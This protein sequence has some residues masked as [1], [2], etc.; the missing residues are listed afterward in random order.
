M[1]EINRF[2]FSSQEIDILTNFQ[3]INPSLVFK[4]T[5]LETENESGSVSGFYN[6]DKDKEFG[7]FGIYLLQ[8]FITILKE[9]NDHALE[10]KPSE[11]EVIIHDQLNKSKTSYR[12]TPVADS[13]M[14]KDIKYPKSFSS[15][16]EVIDIIFRADK[17]AQLRKIGDII[18]FDCVYINT[19]IND[20]VR[21]IGADEDRQN[22]E[23]AYEVEINEIDVKTNALDETLVIKRPEFNMLLPGY[24]Y[25]L[26]VAKSAK[27][28]YMTNW[29][30]VG[31]N[32]LEYF[33]GIGKED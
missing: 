7:E 20:I 19:E 18:G 2:S 25:R 16:P 1:T 5:K 24:D 26:I 21:F 30:N 11:R 10:V 4:G 33:I 12:T 3:V 29:S 14:F 27:G 17:I 8:Q 32:S 31:I 28:N 22:T 13:G 23:N 6:F 15:Q 9:M